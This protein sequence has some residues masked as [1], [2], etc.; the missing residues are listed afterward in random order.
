MQELCCHQSSGGKTSKMEPISILGAAASAI[1]VVQL[2]TQSL[3]SLLRLQKRFRNADLTVRLLVT[4]LS[5]LRTALNQISD[6]VDK[7]VHGALS[8]IL[9]DLNMS[10]DGC[11]FLIETLNDRLSRLEYDEDTALSMRKR[12]Q[13][14][15]DEKERTE[16]LT[17]LGHNISAL[18]LLL[19]AM[20]WYNYMKNSFTPEHL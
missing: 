8:R 2:C 10:L 17:L 5:T 7:S 12:A 9:P 13:T 1:T 20:Q 11:R 14:V 6:W 16:F 18:Q 4:Q 19:T 15:W 3:N